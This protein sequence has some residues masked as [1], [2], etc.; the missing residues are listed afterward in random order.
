[1]GRLIRFILIALGVWALLGPASAQ[2]LRIVGPR[3]TI[4]SPGEVPVELRAV[5]VAAEIDGALAITSVEMVFHNPNRRLLEGELQFPLLAGQSVVGFA[6]DVDGRMR[7]AVPIDKARGQAVFED[8]TR[9]RVDPGLL[10][11]TDG[12]NYKVRVYPI[13]A[14]GTRRI[15]VRYVES[16][17]VRGKDRVYRLPLEYARGVRDLFF[18]ARVEGDAPRVVAAGALGELAFHRVG[19]GWRAAVKRSGAASGMLELAIPGRNGA[20]AS[21]QTF[22]DATYFHAEGRVRVAA[23]ARVL[24]RVVQIAWDSSGS[25]AARDFARE[26]ELLGAYFNAAR[27]VEVHLV[28]VRDAAEPAATFRVRNGDWSALR[29]ALEE[30]VHDGGTN[31]AAIP[32]D[33]E[34]GELLLFSDGLAN[35]GEGSLVARTIPV[36]AVSSV[37]G[38]AAA[39]L[40]HFAESTGGRF[41]DL[42]V[43]S[44]AAAREKLLTAS[45][46]IVSLDGEGVRDLVAASPILTDGRFAIAGVAIAA[47][48][49]IRVTIAHADGRR[50]VASL[51]IGAPEGEGRL[52]ATTWA[53]WKLAALEGEYDLHRGEIRRIGRAFGLVTRETSLIVLERVED[54]VRYEVDPPA[55][56][57]DTYARLRSQAAA[58]VDADRHAHVE[59]IV[60]RFREKQAWWDK[61][62]PKDDRTPFVDA[63][64]NVQPSAPAAL[65]AR[66][67]PSGAAAPAEARMLRADA[68]AGQPVAKKEA[69]AAATTTIRMRPWRPDAPYAARMREADADRAYRVYLDERPDYVRS[70]AFFLDAADILIDKGRPELAVRVLSNLA[71][72]DLENRHLLRLLGY[73]L[74]QAKQPRL[75]IP[76][77]RKVLILAPEE[78]Q[79]YRDLGLA[80]AADRQF[81]KAVDQ[82]AEVVMRPWHGRFPDIELIALAELNAIVATAGQPLDVA[83]LDPRLARNLPLDLRVILTWDA[84]NTDIDLWVTDP[85]GEKAYYGHQ[86]TYQGGRMSLDFT[87]GYGPEEFS[88]KSA[89]P[90][91]YK[92]EA[93][94]YGHRQQAV[95]GA[96]T[97]QVKLTT[98][99]GTA[100]AEEQIVTLRLKGASE[101]VYVGDFEVRS[102]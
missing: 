83:R 70:S 84:D 74:L 28:R 67:A 5:R 77:F 48:A 93:N 73:R 69:E 61:D 64:K 65:A 24:P 33:R 51:E 21:V 71:E 60:Q 6:L 99:F 13:P 95:A 27:D 89:K 53:A 80:Y 26:R 3:L 59:R 54:Y 29:R 43:D 78:P 46:R 7:D 102:R 75:A 4:A 37:T 16:L 57:A 49:R 86:L 81:Q 11:A 36:F 68:P 100:R 92:V 42:L 35:F 98:G 8:I 52:A 10:Q 9:A 1:M 45:A 72:M 47:R 19:N 12:N 44:P 79:S 30:T 63:L 22:R 55:E 58:R 15:L 88:L 82:L 31:L 62:F 2:D 101:V 40:R 85:N 97:L 14:D 94:F 38:A 18:E 66:P 25:M 56:L 91:V 34:A 32:E 23:R 17:A 20:G 50:E 96:T 76:V 39:S 41:I 90:G 87:G